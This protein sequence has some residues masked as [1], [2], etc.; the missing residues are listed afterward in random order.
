MIRLN[1]CSC[2]FGKHVF[3]TGAECNCDLLTSVIRW[4]EVLLNYNLFVSIFPNLCVCYWCFACLLC[5]RTIKG[6]ER[7]QWLLCLSNPS[8]VL[9]IVHVLLLLHSTSV[10]LLVLLDKSIL[11]SIWNVMWWNAFYAPHFEFY[12]VWSPLDTLTFLWFWYLHWYSFHYFQLVPDF[13]LNCVS[14]KQHT[15]RSCIYPF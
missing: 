1:E 8:L 10:R 12:L 7:I 11:L 6:H 14:Y 9:L 15:V 13:A 3:P 4:W 2:P 5:Q